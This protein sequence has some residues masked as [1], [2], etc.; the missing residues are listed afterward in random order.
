MQMFIQKI[1]F[2]YNLFN[3]KSFKTHDFRET[4]KKGIVKENSGLNVN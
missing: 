3:P 1:R 4:K 2:S